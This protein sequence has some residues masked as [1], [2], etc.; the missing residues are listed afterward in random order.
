MPLNLTPKVRG[1]IDY[2]TVRNRAY[3]LKAAQDAY[4]YFPIFEKY[5]K[6]YNLPQE[7]KYLSII[8][9][10]LNPRAISR[11]GAAGLWQFVPSTGRIYKLHQDWYVDERLDPYAATEAA[12]KYLKELYSY[13]NDWELALAAYNSGPGRVRESYK[14]IWL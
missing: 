1:F 12:C 14:K 5:L 3:T 7:L 11:A 2:F 4:Y 8:E 13:F 6:K 10:G 9:S